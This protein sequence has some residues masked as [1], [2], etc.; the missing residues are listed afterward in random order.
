MANSGQKRVSFLLDEDEAEAG[1]SKRPNNSDNPEMDPETAK[2]LFE[3]GAFLIL[4]GV[5][6]GTEIG[7]DMQSWRSGADFL[8]NFISF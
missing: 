7:I 3:T 1:P 8:G 2:K 4:T 5:P 6:A